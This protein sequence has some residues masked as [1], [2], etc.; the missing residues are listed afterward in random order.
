MKDSLLREDPKVKVLVMGDMNDDP[1]NKS[2]YECLSA[3]GEINEVGA[4]DMYNPWYNVLVRREQELCSI[5]ANGISL[6]RLS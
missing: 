3:K 4:D 1:T 2:M 6:T 5:R